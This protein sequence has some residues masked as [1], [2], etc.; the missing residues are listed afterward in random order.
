MAYPVSDAFKDALS[1]NVRVASR[2]D[3]L[4]DGAVTAPGSPLIDGSV[5]VE[6]NQAVRRHGT[7]SVE[8][9]HTEMDPYG[10]EVAVY[11][12]LYLPPGTPITIPATQTHQSD[13]TVLE[14]VPMGVFGI[15]VPEIVDD[16]STLVTTCE[17][18][19]R[20]NS[21]SQRRL[22]NAYHIAAGT[23]L[24]TAIQDLIDSRR[25][26]LIFA[27]V[28][29]TAT[30]PDLLLE[31]EADPWAEAQKMAASAGLELLFDATGRCVLRPIPAVDSSV[32]AWKYVSGVGCQ[33]V[34]A[35]RKRTSEGVYSHGIAT[36]ETT[37][38][39]P[40]VRGDAYD[41]KHRS[42]TYYKGAFGDRP[43]WLRSPMITTQEQADDAA[44]GL[45][46]RTSGIA[47]GITL[48]AVANPAAD[49]DDTVLVNRKAL[50][51]NA[52]YTLDSLT[53]TLGPEGRLQ[54]S[55]RTRRVA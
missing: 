45:V 10:T 42:P 15:E 53:N 49:A 2:A 3:V 40:P 30:T 5:T 52:V 24:G 7:I 1:S 34:K 27:F 35:A 38:N 31:E 21:I 41:T 46:N 20:A 25:S 43:T 39:S 8:G 48:E 32:T 11:G 9:L 18:Y 36:G 44:A 19:D 47:E 12:G 50:A 14:L 16:G 37:D 29:T 55:T 28:S 33:L 23:N 17:I 6:A 26:D 54:A 51:V 13:G 22:P 4:R